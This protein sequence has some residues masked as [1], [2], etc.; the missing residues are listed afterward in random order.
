MKYHKS[1]QLIDIKIAEAEYLLRLI[2]HPQN[3]VGFVEINAIVNAFISTTRNVTWTMQYVLRDIEGFNVWY[4]SQQNRMKEDVLSSFFNDYRTATVHKGQS[5]ITCGSLRDSVMKWHF[6]RGETV[7][8]DDVHA[9]CRAYF[10]KVLE[11]VF[12]CYSQFKYTMSGK[13][14]YS[15]ENF[16]SMGKTIDDA[17]MEIIGIRGWTS[18]TGNPDEESERWPLLRRNIVGC[19]IQHLFKEYLGKEFQEPS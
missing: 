13:W 8:H 6:T 14:Y 2:T 15:K 12:E 17:D 9:P 10:I 11:I 1:A 5:L 19:E 3:R 7:S 18:V 16:E 4:S